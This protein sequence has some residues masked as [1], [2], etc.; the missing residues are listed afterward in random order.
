MLE[1]RQLTRFVEKYR[2][3][4]DAALQ[5]HFDRGTCGLEVEWNV[6][7]AAL[8]PLHHVGTGPDAR[9]FIEVL[10]ER[11]IPPFLADRNAL[12]VFHWMTEWVTRPYYHPLGAVYE[13]RVLEG[14]LLNALNAAGLSFGERLYLGSG[15]VLWPIEVGPDAIPPAWE[16]AKRRYLERCVALYGNAL[17]TAGVHVNVS[18]PE[19]LFSLDFLHQSDGERAGR[20]LVGW[21]NA[22]Y[23]R[24]AR[25]LRAFSA[26][27]IATSAGSPLRGA[28]R[29]NEA[30]VRLTEYD[31]NR[32]VR[33]PNPVEL[34]VAALY[35]SHPDYVQVSSDLVRRRVRFGNNNWTPTRARSD[36]ASVAHIIHLTT[37]QLHEV[38]LKGIFGVGEQDVVERL[39]QRVEVENMIAR[40]ELPMMRVE[41]RTDEGG[42]AL[43]LDE[44]NAVAKQLLLIWSY[45]D[46]SFGE[47]FTYDA[48]HIERARRNE[49]A[50]AEHGLRAQ[51]EHPFGG[52]TVG[53]RAFLQETLNTLRPLA[54]E[55]GWDRYLEPLEALARGAPNTAEQVRARLRSACDEDGI[56]PRAALQELAEQR[57]AQVARDVEQIR[58]ALG[59]LG[60]ETPKLRE[61]FRHAALA[62]AEDP[63]APLRFEAPVKVSAEAASTDKTREIVDLAQ[64]LVRIPSVT[65]CPNERI[66]DVFRAARFIA[67][68]LRNA[69]AQVRFFDRAQYP[70]VF[71]HFPGQMATPV[72]LSGHFDVVEPAPDDSQFEPVIDGDYLWGRGSADM[73]TVVATYLV[74]LRDVLRRRPTQYPPINLLLVGNEENGEA[75]PVGTPHVLAELAERHDYA[76]RLMIA[77]E[78]TGEKGDE[79]F[80]EICVENRGV[81]RLALVARGVREHTGVGAR[82][83][84]L[85]IRIIEARN[86]IERI[87]RDCLTVDAP[88]GWQ[89][90]YRFPFVTVGQP[91]V[92]NITADAGYLGLEV[93]PIPQDDVA[94][95]LAA[96]REQAADLDLEVQ[97]QTREPGVAC[98]RHNPYLGALVDA[99]HGVS[100]QAPVLGRK[101]PGTSG[102]F[103]P[104]GQA[105]IWGQT[106]IGPHTA[107]ERHFIPSIQPY[108]DALM[109]F[110][111]EA[112][113]RRNDEA[114]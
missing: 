72:M 9:S 65:N 32:L 41:V 73:K 89:T 59:A 111:D 64:Q 114:T 8:R 99:M 49:R 62:A 11:F 97:V 56:V 3:A 107:A 1:P 106:G 84:D 22:A 105:V 92:Y 76:P 60:D 4:V 79:L 90:D 58:N 104:G 36:P 55:L 69:G 77:G 16:L 113:K 109:R 10:R 43:A 61:L 25:I 19:P 98:D 21:R 71:A 103:A 82:V 66:E 17:A 57:E 93:R 38:H 46:E 68:Y 14:C 24:G 20:S 7:N 27:F 34:D 108:Y 95:L 44:A 96:I 52:Q 53:M 26:L 100:G 13:A 87:L 51:I 30:V 74:W 78:R 18:L 31:S 39:A 42:H 29:G 40:V 67:A 37:E 91:G 75:E 85:G 15:N 5:T 110:A 2:L 81:V 94:G 101:K 12:E 102:R 35:R 112:T 70:A 86:A 45:G 28:W 48:E 54:A 23:I 47:A 88:D 50:A 83:P 63:S 80:G 6:V 33:F